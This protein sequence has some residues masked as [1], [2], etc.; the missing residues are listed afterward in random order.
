MTGGWMDIGQGAD[1]EFNYINIV[2]LM[3]I[4]LIYKCFM[5]KISLYDNSAGKFL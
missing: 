4:K 5:C 2:A 3:L 1:V